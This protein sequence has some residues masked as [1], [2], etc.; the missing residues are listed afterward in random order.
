M[1]QFVR[2]RSILAVLLVLVIAPASAHQGPR[3]RAFGAGN[4][5]LELGGVKTG[6]FRS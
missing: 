2:S 5:F 1:K 3:S 4:V 6:G